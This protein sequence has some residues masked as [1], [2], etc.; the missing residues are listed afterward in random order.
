MK[1]INRKLK[2]VEKAL[3]VIICLIFLYLATV[4]FL[5]FRDYS[6]NFISEKDLN[7]SNVTIIDRWNELP[8]KDDTLN[9]IKN[10]TNGIE[11]TG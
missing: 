3:A 4:F 10:F 5:Y 6:K 7:F 11:T 1:I 9:R 2:F 8:L